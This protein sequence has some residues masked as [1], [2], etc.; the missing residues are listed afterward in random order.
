MTRPQERLALVARDGKRVPVRPSGRGNGILFAV[1][2]FA[3]ADPQDQAFADALSADLILEFARFHNVGV[4]S[5]GASFACRAFADDVARV[6]RELGVQFVLEGT[7][8]RA[9]AQLRITSRLLGAPTGEVLA[10]ERIERPIEEF[11]ACQEEIAG[12]IVARMAPE[13]DLA[14]LR[15]AEQIP[16]SAL[17]VPDMVLRA[18]AML[19]RGA[20]AEDADRIGRGMELARRATEQEPNYAEAWRVLAL[21]H[22]ICGERGAF[23]PSSEAEYAAADAAAAR[24]RA[25]VPTSYAAHAISGHVA[26]RQ[27]RHADS[28]ES[29][30]HA[31]ELNPNAILTM[32]WLSWEESNHGLAESA[33]AHAERSLELSPRDHISYLGHWALAL[34]LW[35]G[36]NL[37][38]STE[39]VRR[40]VAL[41]PQFGGYFLLLAANLAEQGMM[42]EAADAVRRVRQNCPGLIESRLAGKTYFVK[43][44]LSERYRAAL[45]RAAGMSAAPKPTQAAAL[46]A[47]T[48]RE[49]EVLRLVARGMSNAAIGEALRISEHTAKRHIANILLKLDLP[50]RSAASTLAGKHGL[51]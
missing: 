32:R 9:G 5:K 37:P 15:R 10:S 4:S 13:L 11:A 51:I 34:A 45:A 14:S 2:P 38:E 46:A 29:L 30:R 19:L 24:L 3:A 18:R 31:H 12:E 16:E 8:R 27:G 1:L 23:G 48:D 42:A 7:V 22:C 20:E 43:P 49:R 50:T 25:L 47:L 44:E 21:G 41:T 6:A 28:L 40:A 33:R 35:V 26:M 17:E 39:H 36:G